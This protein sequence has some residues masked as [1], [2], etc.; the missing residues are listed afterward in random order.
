MIKYNWLRA[1]VFVIVF[2]RSMR[3]IRNV[4]YKSE[5]KLAKINGKRLADF[6]EE[7]K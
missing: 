3:L 6:F 4:W 5:I 1:K 7:R 2:L